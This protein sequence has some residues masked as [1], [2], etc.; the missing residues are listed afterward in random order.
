MPSRRGGTEQSKPRRE[1]AAAVLRKAVDS[2]Q[3]SNP[4]AKM[5]IMGDFNDNP[6]DASISQI[7]QATKTPDPASKNS[8]YDAA[9]VFNWKAGEGSEWYRGDW[10]RF[11]QIIVSPAL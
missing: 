3:L 9:N 5:I 6:T 4:G 10:S 11:I 7:L 2:I 1:I 8:L